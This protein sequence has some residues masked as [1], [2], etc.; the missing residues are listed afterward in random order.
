MQHNPRRESTRPCKLARIGILRHRRIHQ[1]AQLAKRSPLIL[2]PQPQNLDPTL[3]PHLSTP[4]IGAL[5]LKQPQRPPRLPSTPPSSLIGALLVRD[6]EVIRNR[7]TQTHDTDTPPTT[8]S[9]CCRRAPTH[10]AGSTPP[11]TCDSPAPSTGE[12]HESPCG[13]E[14]PEPTGERED[15]TGRENRGG[16]DP[17]TTRSTRPARGDTETN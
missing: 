17:V 2:G 12:A 10:P 9:E 3:P 4:Q 7:G 11:R 6:Q 13:T 1:L 15:V 5:S 14:Q 8:W 16:R